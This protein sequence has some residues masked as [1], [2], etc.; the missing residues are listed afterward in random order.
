R[1]HPKIICGA[2]QDY[3][4]DV[5][6]QVLAAV[7]DRWRGTCERKRRRNYAVCRLA[8][9]AT[10]DGR[11]GANLVDLRALRHV[12]GS[13]NG[14]SAARLSRVFSPYSKNR[15]AHRQFRDCSCQRRLGEALRVV[16]GSDS[17]Y[18]RAVVMA[19]AI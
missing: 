9:C 16:L 12:S 5:R 13:A 14:V 1:T 15:K 19:A 3:G 7:D 6:S 17:R 8:M 18:R 2:I 11:S 4:A 10:G